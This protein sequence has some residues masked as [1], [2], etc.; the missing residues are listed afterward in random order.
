MKDVTY[1][2]CV[3]VFVMN[4]IYCVC[5]VNVFMI[6]VIYCIRIFSAIITDVTQLLHLN[7]YIIVIDI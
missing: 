4:V 2:V 7:C 3:N 5:V 6:V 1:C